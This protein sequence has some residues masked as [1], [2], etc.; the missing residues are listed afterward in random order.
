MTEQELAREQIRRDYN[1]DEYGIIISPGKFEGSQEYMPFFY[2]LY[3]ELLERFEYEC[4]PLED[5]LVE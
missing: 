5:A 4:E 1:V 2:E 3:L